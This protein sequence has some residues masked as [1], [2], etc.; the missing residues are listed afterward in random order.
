MADAERGIGITGLYFDDASS[1]VGKRRSGVGERGTVQVG[2]LHQL[3][4]AA[5]ES[6]LAA[7]R[8]ND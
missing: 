2:S 6:T 8:I 4:D 5:D 7:K 1:K 3:G